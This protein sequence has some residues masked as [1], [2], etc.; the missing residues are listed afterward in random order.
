MIENSI[1]RMLLPFLARSSLAIPDLPSC[2]ARLSEFSNTGELPCE[3][4]VNSVDY[5]FIPL[6]FEDLLKQ[7]CL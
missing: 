6:K 5:S 7:G 4:P 3:E 1:K 2:K